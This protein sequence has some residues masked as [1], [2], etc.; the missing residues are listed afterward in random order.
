MHKALVAR[1]P[2][3][4]QPRLQLERGP[5][6]PHQASLREL[7]EEL[8][9][10]VP[11]NEPIER[12]RLGPD[13]GHDLPATAWR[14]IRINRG[15]IARF[16]SQQE[17]ERDGKRRGTQNPPDERTF[18]AQFLDAPVNLLAEN[19]NRADFSTEPCNAQ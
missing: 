4:C 17:P 11:G 1:L 15:R 7:P 18:Y 8:G 19:E 2:L 9:S 12:P 6:H 13:G 14:R 16:A 10:L 3:F 5:V